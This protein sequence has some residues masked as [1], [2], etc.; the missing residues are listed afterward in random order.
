MRARKA[1]HSPAAVVVVAAVLLGTLA[2]FTPAASAHGSD[3][4]PAIARV[5]RLAPTFEG[6]LGGVA[7]TSASDAWAVG[8]DAN[9]SLILHW[10]GK[11]WQKVPAA[12][13]SPGNDDLDA[14]AASSARNAWAVGA[15][16]G[17]ALVLHWNGTAWKAVPQPHALRNDGL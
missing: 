8:G 11:K 15:L 16:G 4:K 6:G 14:V 10:N 7:A 9:N 13:P 5:P 12:N 3:P 2:A 17:N 1:G